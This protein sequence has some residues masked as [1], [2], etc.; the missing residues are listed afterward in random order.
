MPSV[1]RVPLIV[2]RSQTEQAAI[3]DAV[4]ASGSSDQHFLV[5]P[6]DASINLRAVL[7]HE[8]THRFETEL[9][10]RV[11]DT[12]EWI[13]EGLADHE[14]DQWSPSD[15]GTVRAALAT[16]SI[17]AVGRF[18][19]SDRVWGHAVFDFVAAEYGLRGLRQYVSAPQGA[20]FN[21]DSMR[22]A[23]GVSVDDFDWAFKMFIR[24]RYS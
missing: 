6:I 12:P 9:P 17:P 24:A 23:L 11:S 15:L 18:S 8:L 4:G 22:S 7:V 14:A 13:A 5:L 10:M 16:Q 2:I 1:Q 19:E 20:S 3:V 21:Q